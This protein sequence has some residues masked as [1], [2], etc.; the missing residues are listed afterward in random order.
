MHFLRTLSTALAAALLPFLL[1]AQLNMSFVGNLDYQAL[2]GSDISDIWGYVDQTGIEYALIGVNEGGVSVVSLEDPTNPVEVFFFPGQGTIWRDLKVWNDHV[3]VTNEGGGG[4]AIIDL[5]PLPFS[6]DLPATHWLGQDWEKA[7]N[8]FIDE[9]GIAY[10][11]GADRGNGGTIFLD[12]TQDP[13]QPVEVGQFDAWYTHDGVVRGDTLYQANIN[14]GFFSIVNVADKQ[15][16]VLLGTRNTGN[17]FTHNCWISDNGNHLFSTDEVVGGFLGSYDISDPSDIEELQIFRSAP[18]SGTIPHNTHYINGYIVT[19]Y[20]RL[21]TTIHDVSRPWNVVEVGHYDHCPL[22]G[23]G[24][25]GGWG[26]YPWLPSGRI[27]SSDIEGGLYVLQPTYTPA[28]WLE[29]TVRNAQTLVPVNQA[30]V[31]LLPDL[32]VDVTGFDGVYATGHHTATTVDVL[33]QASGYAPLTIT[34]VQLVQGEVVELDILLEPLIPFT[35]QG[36]VVDQA[37]GLP[38]PGAQV[39]MRNAFYTFRTEADAE[40]RFSVEDFFSSTYDLTAGQWGWHSLCEPRNIPFGTEDLLVELEAGYYDDMYFDFGW[41]VTGTA[42]AGMWERGAPIG[43]TFQGNASNP[44]SDVEGDCGDQAYVTGNGGGNAGNDDLDDG[45]S[46]LTSPLFSLE[47]LTDPAVRYQRWFYNGGG[48]SPPNDLMRIRLTNGTD[49]VALETITAATPGMSSWVAR[50]YRVLDHITPGPSM[51]LL[52][53][54]TDDDPGHLVEGGLDLFEVVELSNVGIAG[55]A[56]AQVR[57]WPNPGRD[58]FTLGTGQAGPM[59][60]ALHDAQGRML[61]S[62]R[63]VPAGGGTFAHALPDGFYLLRLTDAR[64]SAT[65]LRLVVGGQ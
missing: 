21:G 29:G 46:L 28:C 17:D 55:E 8:L 24:F 9:H 23:A 20:Y 14:A 4:L 65:T 53:Y 34:G 51:R 37:S 33:V 38:V 6:T 50:E 12:L 61:W 27:I 26:T 19:S 60:M 31:R 40:G 35:L 7:H 10:I 62:D 41:T 43:T 49:T 39:D 54:I 18:G 2:H 3:Y 44:G 48:G 25:N 11:F 52:A 15:A 59:R 58:A 1:P 63:P 16:P 32:G 47:A 64:G 22:E 13:F 45:W 30:E 36:T 5:S 56:P 42:T 57:L